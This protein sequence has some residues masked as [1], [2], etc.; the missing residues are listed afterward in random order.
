MKDKVKE[1]GYEDLVDAESFRE[2]PKTPQDF[3]E[4]YNALCEEYKFMIA[5]VPAFKARDDGTWSIVLQTTLQPLKK[6]E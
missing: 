6:D 4:K 5:V 3:M 1:A 2:A